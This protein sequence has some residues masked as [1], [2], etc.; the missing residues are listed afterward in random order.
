M[1]KIASKFTLLESRIASQSQLHDRVTQLESKHSSSNDLHSR[2]AHLES[3]IPNHTI[4][5]DRLSRLESKM[6][7]DPEHD[8]LITRI[9]AKLDIIE[10]S[11]KMKLNSSSTTPMTTTRLGASAAEHPAAHDNTEIRFLQERV[12]KLTALRARYSREEK[13]LMG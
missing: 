5:S 13:E 8:R 2:L 11:Q 12:D 3:K 4:L 6:Q 9:N 7:P 10:N 1:T